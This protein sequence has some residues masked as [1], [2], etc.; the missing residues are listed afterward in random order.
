MH[1][2]FLIVR[3]VICLLLILFPCLLCS[4]TQAELDSLRQIVRNQGDQASVSTF[5]SLAQQHIA[6]TPSF[7]SMKVYADL[8]MNQAE[9]RGDS[10]EFALAHYVLGQ[11]YSQNNLFD[12]SEYYYQRSLELTKPLGNLQL[13][14]A[15]HNNLGRN[16]LLK[17]EFEPALADFFESLRLE[18]ERGEEGELQQVYGNIALVYASQG[19]P[20]EGLPYLYKALPIAFADRDTLTAIQVYNNLSNF[21]RYMEIL[22]SAAYFATQ[23]LDLSKM[24]GIHEGV[25]RAKS[26]LGQI[27][28]LQGD[29][30][31]SKKWAEAAIADVGDLELPDQLDGLYLNL[32]HVH[33]HQGNTQA[34]VEAGE[35]ALFYSRKTYAPGN[36]LAS[37]EDATKF[38]EAAGNYKIALRYTEEAHTIEDSLFSVEK[39]NQLRRLQTEFETERK[40]QEIESLQQQTKI[41]ELQIKQ[42]SYLAL[43]ILLLAVLGLGVL[44][45][46]NRQRVLKEQEQAMEARQQALRTQMNPHFLFHALSSIQDYIYS[47]EQAETAALYLSKFAKLMRL[48]L[49]NSREDLI[50]LEQEIL[51]LT[52]YMDLQQIRYQHGFSYEIHLDPNIEVENIFIPPMVAQPFIENALEHG[53]IHEQEHGKLYVRIS[54]QGDRLEMM[55]E[56][57]GIGRKKA[58]E[59]SRDRDHRSLATEITEDR[60][61]LIRR[62]YKREVSLSIT[63]RMEKGEIAGVNVFIA[64]PI[65]TMK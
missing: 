14:A 2:I 23:V 61:Q 44:Y 24:I 1:H 6:L 19:Q 29:I 54:I 63:D 58:A 15:I 8:A 4:Q 43:S 55:V 7:D 22:D 38:H 65:I 51:T 46:V 39:I 27:T 16:H 45:I 56:D 48:I 37:L 53:R 21:Y 34:A 3:S 32:G 52:N 18:E 5:L 40:Q 42:R 41:Q 35:K 31:A 47:N 9:Q 20:R 28:F 26:L 36:I 13:L 49:E 12:S 59:R 50:S 62:K 33:H 11:A 57:N 30:A 64:L 25:V 10:S 17:D 60:L